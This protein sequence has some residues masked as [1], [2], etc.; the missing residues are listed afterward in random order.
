[1]SPFSSVNG[2]TAR[3]L[4]IYYCSVLTFSTPGPVVDRKIYEYLQYFNLFIYEYKLKRYDCSSMI[5]L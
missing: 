3:C 5:I 2:E 1:M 4:D